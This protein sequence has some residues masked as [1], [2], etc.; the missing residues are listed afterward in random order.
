MRN[1]VT[2]FQ[3]PSFQSGPACDCRGLYDIAKVCLS[4]LGK[5]GDAGPHLPTLLP[6]ILAPWALSHPTRLTALRLAGSEDIKA[7]R[8]PCASTVIPAFSYPRLLLYTSKFWD[9]LS[10]QQ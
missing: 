9:L 2:F 7:Q 6:G 8:G 1:S 4:R 10:E 3:F 5:K